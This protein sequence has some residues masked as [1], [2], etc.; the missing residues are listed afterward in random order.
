MF[1][2]LT[3]LCSVKKP[4]RKKEKGFSLKN[5]VAFPQVFTNSNVLV[6]RN[7]L[8]EVC[9]LFEK[10]NERIFISKY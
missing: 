10:L 5:T 7:F 1:Q 3:V 9:K 8:S 2:E 4:I 6:L